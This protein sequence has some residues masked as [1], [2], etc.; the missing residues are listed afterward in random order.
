MKVR[1]RYTN[2][3]SQS[4]KTYIA[5]KLKEL[6]IQNGLTQH[7][8]A[9]NAAISANSYARIERGEVSPSLDTFEKLVKALGVK[10]S[11]ILPF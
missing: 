8:L 11:D 6:R 1:Y 7:D 9:N 10:S 4:S 5:K 3:M 2:H